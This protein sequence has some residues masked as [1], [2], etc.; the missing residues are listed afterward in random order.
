MN[1]VVIYYPA[2]KPQ[3]FIIPIHSPRLETLTEFIYII[4]RASPIYPQLG[5]NF[6]IWFNGVLC[7]M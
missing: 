3:T 1:G 7:K 4:E 2:R 6:Q 5:I